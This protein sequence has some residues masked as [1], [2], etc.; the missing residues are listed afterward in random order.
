[1]A[2]TVQGLASLQKKLKALPAAAKAAIAG[3][4]EQGAQDI[5]AQM[6]NLCP[7]GYPTL[8]ESIGWTWGKAPKNAMV[9]G[10]I[11]GN[12]GD[13][14]ITIY[15]GNHKAFYARWVEFG[16]RS[17]INKGLFPGTQNPG[18]RSHPFFYVAYR[19]NKRTVKGRITRA[20]NKSAKAIAA[21]SSGGNP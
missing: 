20:I 21:Q 2:A 12:I 17:H 15:A 6:K 4:M 5:V 9:I 1:M 18:T 16:T 3:A 8:R 19:A 11:K 7:D 14:V 13:L 10:T